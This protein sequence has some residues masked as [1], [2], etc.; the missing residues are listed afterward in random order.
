MRRGLNFTLTTR[1]GALDLLGVM[2]GGGDH[3]ALLPRSVEIEVFGVK[4]RCLDLPTL[5]AAK[6]AVGRPKDLESLAELEAIVAEDKRS[7]S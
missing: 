5:I 7:D 2:T 6:R 4:C 1:L 3:E